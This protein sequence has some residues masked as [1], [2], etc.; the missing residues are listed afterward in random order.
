MRPTIAPTLVLAVVTSLLAQSPILAAGFDG[1]WQGHMKCLKL[2]ET[3][4]A[5]EVPVTMIVKG[6]EVTMSRSVHNVD[7]T[8][9]VGTESGTGTIG[10]DGAIKLSSSWKNPNPSI[11]FAFTA[12]YSGT[13]TGNTASLSGTEVWTIKGNTENRSCS[14]TLTH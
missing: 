4:G 12:T 8:K 13:A 9:V 11:Q 5:Q 1:K 6:G 3:T 14:I 7:N 2:A 10:S